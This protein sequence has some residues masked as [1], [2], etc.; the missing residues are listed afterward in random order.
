MPAPISVQL[1]SLREAMKDGKHATVLAALGK[2]GFVGVETAG[3]YGLKPA[4][5]K[6]LASDNGLVVSSTH[7]PTPTATNVA[8]V[9]DTNRALGS[10][11]A[12]SGFGPNDFKDL[13][14]IRTTADKLNTGISLLKSSGVKFAMHNH[15]WEFERLL[16]RAKIDWLLDLVP[17]LH[18]EIDTYWASNF[19]AE[20]PAEQVRRFAARTPY[21]HLKDGPFIKDQP[22]VACGGGKQDFP[23]I[24]GA[25]DPKLLQWVVVELDACATDMLTAVIESK[26][27]LVDKGLAR[28]R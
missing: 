25:A 12:I 6:K 11:Y 13:D 18:L 22:M 20:V 4:E 28:G 26:R 27:F 9:I 14:T 16:G 10:P 7:G 23:A 3:L 1:Y 2:A 21:L 5:F 24:V 15:W 8:E 19:Q 17:D